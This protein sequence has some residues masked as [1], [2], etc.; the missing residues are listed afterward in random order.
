MCTLILTY[1]LTFRAYAGP[2]RKCMYICVLGLCVTVLLSIALVNPIAAH[3]CIHVFT[4]SCI[5]KELLSTALVILN[6]ATIP[7]CVYA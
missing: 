1:A 7:V 5:V 6:D 3:A 2:V 4:H